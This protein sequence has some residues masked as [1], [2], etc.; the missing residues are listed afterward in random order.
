MKIKV[1]LL[2]QG[3]VLSEDIYAVSNKPILR[4]NTILEERHIEVI[5]AF[6]IKEVD[7]KKGASSVEELICNNILEE[8]IHEES[9][10]FLDHYYQSVQ[11]YKKMFTSW[12]A[13]AA[14]NI[15]H[16][17]ELILPLVDKAME[18]W[19]EVMDLY[20]KCQSTEY[21]FHHSIGVALL[22]AL[23][24]KQLNYLQGEMNQIALAGLLCDCGMSKINNSILFK[25]SVLTK[26][27]YLEIKQHPIYSYK[28]LKDLHSLKEGVKVSVL[29]HHERL[30]GSG[31]PL[32]IK[33][34]QL[35]SIGKIL[36]VADTYY[37]MVS[38]R[39]YRPSLSPFYTL[40]N[41]EK[42]QFGKFDLTVLKAL[43]RLFISYVK[44]R[45]VG[46]S[47]GRV[48][49]IVFIDEHNPTKPLIK[50]LN[51][52]EVIFLLKDEKVKVSEVF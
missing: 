40:E 8:T 11:N 37:A 6:F 18:N 17:R 50:L 1:S 15:S 3:Y 2:R 51:S 33:G 23:I 39:P 7:I 14:V 28:M 48:G 52:N 4:K 35:H 22:S 30:E 19:N 49:E 10:S 9:S 41:I 16:V 32:G 24:A 12:Q 27:E 29:Q 13:G 46:L 5:K 38:A 25:N 26:E 21:I 20:K 34:D 43:K 44:G 45:K 36:S 42:D 31:Y 47:D